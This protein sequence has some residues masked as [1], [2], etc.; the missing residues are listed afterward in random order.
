[1]FDLVHIQHQVIATTIF[2]VAGIF[3]IATL[4]RIVAQKLKQP[5]V[6]GEL[7]F[8]MLIS[9]ILYFFGVNLFALM[10]EGSA[11]IHIMGVNHT[12]PVSVNELIAVIL[13]TFAR[14]GLLFLLFSVGL[15]S[16]ISTLRKVGVPAVRVAIIG[17][18]MPMLFGVAWVK[19]M[20]P[21]ATSSL[22][23]FVG[24]TLTATSI[25]ITARVLGDS[26]IL[27]TFEAQT[28]IGAAVVDDILGL[29]ILALISQSNLWHIIGSVV[30]FFLIAIL[31][32]PNALRIIFDF[33]NAEHNNHNTLIA[34]F[35]FLL[36]FA[37]LA[38]LLKLDAI[39]GAFVAGVLLH[40]Q[41]NVRTVLAPLEQIFAPMF[42]TM[43]GMQVKLESLLDP[44]VMFIALSVSVIAIVGKILSG[45]GCRQGHDKWLVGL[46]MIPRGEVGLIFAAMGKNFGIFNDNIFAAI[47]IMVML[48]TFLTPIL[49]NFYVKNYVQIKS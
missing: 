20:L 30:G 45:L 13:E 29:V 16:S 6:L 41:K 40:D 7:L 46:G 14:F 15:E 37:W 31:F 28:I 27:H 1:M 10:R 11:I 9:N 2:W 12:G 26:K 34:T 22:T 33:F 35:V 36:A 23:W 47:I 4:G 3:L 43:I 32:G 42:F 38:T 21:D 25:G 24:A 49:L 5:A 48:T 39:I 18:I 44:N 19:I 8:G 17:V